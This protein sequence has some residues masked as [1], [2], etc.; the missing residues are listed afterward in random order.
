MTRRDVRSCE[1]AYPS[2]L[3]LNAF[4]KLEIVYLVGSMNRDREVF[5]PLVKSKRR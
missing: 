3:S 2:Y 1:D 5:V 4:F